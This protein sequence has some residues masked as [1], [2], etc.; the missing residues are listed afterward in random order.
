MK[1]ELLPVVVTIG[2]A[3]LCVV[4]L[5][6]VY[7][8]FGATTVYVLSGVIPTRYGPLPG[9]Y[10]PLGLIVCCALWRWLESRN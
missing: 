9:L 6:I 1:S 10:S 3:V 4:I 5:E 8:T 2:L 7:Q